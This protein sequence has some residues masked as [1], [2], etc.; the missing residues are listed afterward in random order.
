MLSYF[1]RN[2]QQCKHLDF[3]FSAFIETMLFGEYRYHPI[4]WSSNLIITTVTL[5]PSISPTFRIL[6]S[7]V[8]LFVLPT[9]PPVQGKI[10]HLHEVCTPQNESFPFLSSTSTWLSSC[11]HSGYNCSRVIYMMDEYNVSQSKREFDGQ[12]SASTSYI[13]P[14]CSEWKAGS[15]SDVVTALYMM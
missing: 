10:R 9:S 6:H 5:F 7:I 11:K 14:V 2:S 12:V 3:H 15:T 13:S 4:I 8:S 1:Q